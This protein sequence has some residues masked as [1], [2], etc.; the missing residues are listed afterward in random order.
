[1]IIGSALPSPGARAPRA[2]PT[3]RR[4]R[5]A[6]HSALA[7]SR[8]RPINARHGW[9]TPLPRGVSCHELSCQPY[10]YTAYK[11]VMMLAPNPDGALGIGVGFRESQNAPAMRG[12]PGAE[13]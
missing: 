5:R 11:V 7:W 2:A 1:L 10:W 3:R 13:S 12:H 4:I 8:Y 9:V 6:V